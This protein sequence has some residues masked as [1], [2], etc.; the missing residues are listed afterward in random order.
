MR[1]SQAQRWNGDWSP[2]YHDPMHFEVTGAT[3]Q[4]ND[5]ST[6]S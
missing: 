6:K 1:R 3:H 2:A 4:L 5:V